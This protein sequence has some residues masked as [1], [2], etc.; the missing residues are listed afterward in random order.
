[1]IE[2]LPH[3]RTVHVSAEQLGI[4]LPEYRRR[5]DIEIDPRMVDNV[6]EPEEPPPTTSKSPAGDYSDI[7]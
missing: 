7:Y 5:S 6:E 3:T 2:S 1:M 4:T